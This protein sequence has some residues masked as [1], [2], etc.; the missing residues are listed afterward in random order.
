MP[1][2]YPNSLD[3]FA[4]NR[5]DT[6]TMAATHAADHNNE[7]AAINAIE[8]ALGITPF[9]TYSTVRTRL[10]ALE[11]PTINF[12]TGTT[13]TL[14]LV[15]ASDIISMNNA[16]ANSLKIPTDASVPFPTGTQITIRQAGVGVTTVSAV[17]P[18]TTSLNS[19]GNVFGLAGQY[20]YATIIKIAANTWELSGDIA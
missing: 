15:D 13:Y 9:G 14:T 6:T 2:N 4:T 8:A 7:N 20:A 19:R 5:S 17:T 10:D 12:Q 16:A 3:S 18:G 11:T 1:T